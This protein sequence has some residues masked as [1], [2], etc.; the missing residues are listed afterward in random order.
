MTEFELK[1]EVP[2]ASLQR[3]AA[4]VRSGKVSRQRLR[5][6]YYDTQHGALARHGIVVRVRQE[7]RR[8]VQTA[9]A[10]SA[11]PLER[12][13]RLEH[14][15]PLAAPRTLTPPPVD[16][17]RHAGTPVGERIC[18][19]LRLKAGA[20]MPELLPLYETDVQRLQRDVTH[21]GSIIEI[22]FDRGRIVA[23]ARSVAVCELELELKAGDP[24]AAVRLAGEWCATHGLWLSTVSKSMKGQRLGSGTPAAPAVGATASK[25]GRRAGGRAVAV[26]VLQTC[27]EQVLANASEVAGGSN[28]HEHIHQLR[29]GIRRLRTALAELAPLADG[30]DAAWAPPLVDAFRALGK[31]RD[32]GHL[33]DTLQPQIEEAGGPPLDLDTSTADVPDPGAAVRAAAFQNSLLG[34]L[35]FVHGEGDGVGPGGARKLLRSRLGKLH[36][37]VI[38]DGRKFLALDEDSQHGVRKRLKR[39]RYLVEFAAPMFPKRE[40]EPFLAALKPAQD[41]LGLYND[42]LVALHTWQSL[43]GKDV[44]AWFGVGW[45]SARREPNA[46]ACL[47][48]LKRFAKAGPFWE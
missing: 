15:V 39:L 28:D 6:C 45:L 42:E 27:L 37:R 17:E 20:P 16:L 13:E 7:G 11:D 25:F 32:A 41:A 19:A 30:I 1:L 34:I 29:V 9:K 21:G 22:A 18:A 10:P 46:R 40:V 31:Y 26:A 14:N 38:K 12:L 4:Q 43:A 36:A 47:K 5:A 23:G 44:K 33:A 48:A 3:V 24:A 2:A 35:G 8:W